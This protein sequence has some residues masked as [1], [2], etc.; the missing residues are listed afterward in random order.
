MSKKFFSAFAVNKKAEA[1]GAWVELEGV[2]FLLARTASSRYP[3]WQ[4]L[5]DRK[6]KEYAHL[7]ETALKSDTVLREAFIEYALRGWKNLFHPDT[8]EEIPY[9]KDNARHI[10]TDICPDAVGHLLV[11]ASEMA[12]FAAKERELDLKNLSMSSATK[13]DGDSGKSKEK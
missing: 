1:E 6:L 2:E 5:I 13:K 9:S 12:T 11:K 7:G 10:F 4:S 3:E 8:G